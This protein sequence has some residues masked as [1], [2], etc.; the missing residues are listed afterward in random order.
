MRPN[1]MLVIVAGFVLAASIIWWAAVP[2]A[3]AANGSV[4]IAFVT[5]AAP[6]QPF[7]YVTPP[8]CVD[9]SCLPGSD[10][11]GF[12]LWCFGSASPSS[13]GVQADC[14]GTIYFYGISGIPFVMDG[15]ASGSN[16]TYT[17]VV[18]SKDNSVICSLTN[19]T[20][21]PGPSNAIQVTCAS[22]AG[23][24]T[25]SGSVVTITGP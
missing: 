25:T 20:A 2:A 6:G 14:S 17:M 21:N 4:Q 19:L 8:T 22:P 15:F 18:H 13:K 11:V 16:K 12:W 7:N 24:G 1:R 10:L 3:D 5:N 9:H 23:S